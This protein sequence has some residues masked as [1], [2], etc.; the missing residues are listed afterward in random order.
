M[1]EPRIHT[2]LLQ[3]QLRPPP[4]RPGVVHRARLIGRLTASPEVSKITIVAPPGYGKTTLMS[5]WK[6]QETRPTGWLSLDRYDNDPAILHAHIV[7]AFQ[8]AGMLSDI[9][10][11]D[12]RVSS[13]LVISHGVTRVVNALDSQDATGV[14]MLDHAES[15]SSR[16]SNDT[17]AE[18]AARLPPTVQLAIASRTGVRLPVGQMR[19]QGA[20]LELTAT[21]LAMD[22]AEA[23][24]LLANAGVDVDTQH[25]ELINHTEGW[26]AGLYLAASAIKAG[27]SR[28]PTLRISG[29]DRFVA[30]YL[31]EEVLGHVS[32]ARL[33]FLLRTSILNQFCGPLCDAVLGVT[34][35]ART[36]EQLEESNLLVVPL[37]RTRDWYRYH[38]LLQEFL[39]D[40]LVR[41]E[42][43]V[44]AGLHS[45][46][47]E[48]FDA[49]DM[50]EEAIT[51]A[52]A[53][54]D[55]D[56]AARIVGR[57]SQPTF[58]LGR[59]DTARQWLDWFERT[60]R[61]SH[62][63]K[64]TAQGGV[65]FA[66]AGDVVKA[67]RWADAFP[68]GHPE[69]TGKILHGILARDGLDQ[70]RADARAVTQATSATAAWLPSALALEGLADLWDGDV[71]RA[72]SLLARAVSTGERFLGLAAMTIA[73]AARAAIAIGGG[74]WDDATLLATR[75]LDRI[76]DH[77]LERYV[78]SGMAYAVATRCAAHQGQIEVARR[79]LAQA[80][81]I[82]PMLTTA[83]PGISVHT[84]LE[85]ARAHL[86][87][88]DV[89]GARTVLR[90]AADILAERPNLGLLPKEHDEIKTQL[91]TM[92]GKAVGGSALTTAEL[93]LLPLL[94]TH[95][96]FPEIGERLYI[97]RHTVKTQAMSIY[98]KFG[99]SS[100]SEAVQYAADAGLLPA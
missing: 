100:R 71:E 67:D 79:R 35:S 22:R 32:A 52:Q 13:D 37:D 99:A 46:A 63:P 6:E 60:G 91:D 45:K 2:P 19:A 25:D 75:S 28:R 11:G 58:A 78:T 43:D 31:R 42:P 24:E 57:L 70:V 17:I 59:A 94:V 68:S 26:P 69:V 10:P 9:P 8:H 90:Q 16:A 73:L 84:L 47:A 14:L 4:L 83:A 93:R 20:L 53:A 29:K 38:Y 62:Y 30:D 80:T 72:D 34:G 1:G 65:A 5:Q 86:A 49:N 50:P 85:M 97:S 7:A 76:H 3:I 61:I 44:V 96:S 51:H 87:L 36:I 55:G 77:G 56:L 95:L 40:E 41:R 82:R 23:T 21:D 89:T 27:S 48:W 54:D 81:T 39:R 33:S 18:L 66:L 74:D 12:L 15:V 92:T 88:S 98:R 64:I